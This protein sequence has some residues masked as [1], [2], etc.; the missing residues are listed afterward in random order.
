MKFLKRLLLKFTIAYVKDYVR[1]EW[2]VSINKNRGIWSTEFWI[3]LIAAVI[4]IL[5]QKLKWE[6]PTEQIIT[7]LTVIL[8]YIFNRMRLKEKSRL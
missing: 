4:P 5:N 6:I 8:G 2:K 7:I 3:A 1:K